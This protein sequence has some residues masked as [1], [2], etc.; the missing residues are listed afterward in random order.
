MI[1]CTR[2]GVNKNQEEFYKCKY[3]LTTGRASHCK[4]CDYIRKK[5]LLK[6]KPLYE[7][8]RGIVDRCNNPNNSRYRH[9]GGRGIK[10]KWKTYESF[11]T[12]MGSSY[13]KGLTIDRIDNNGNYCKENC[14]WATMKVQSRNKSNNVNYD[15]VCISDLSESLGGAKSLVHTRIKRGWPLEQA[16]NTPKQ[17][18][19]YTMKKIQVNFICEQ[20]AKEMTT[21]KT[22]VTRRFCSYKCWYIKKFNPKKS[23]Y[24][25]KK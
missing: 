2:C 4:E 8:W 18:S 11:Y 23:K 21:T 14:R 13:K 12:D 16:V 7:V 24:L 5:L 17:G 22:A 1:K 3:N 20:C 6:T 25:K 9:Y 15:G 10:C 19:Q